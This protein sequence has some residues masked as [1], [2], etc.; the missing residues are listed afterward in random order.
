MQAALRAAKKELE[1][2][3]LVRKDIVARIRP[4]PDNEK[5][6]KAMVIEI[7]YSEG[8]KA[9]GYIPR[10]LTKFLHPLIALN[11][12]VDVRLKHITF[13]TVYKRVGLYAAIIIERKGPWG[14]KVVEAS[15]GVR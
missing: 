12:I 13:R 14:K 7:N 4:E 1:R 6:S 5:D 3:P 10:E 8:Y 11:K 15:H 9:I 2:P